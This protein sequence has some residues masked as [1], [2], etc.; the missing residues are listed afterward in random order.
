MV[1]KALNGIPIEYTGAYNTLVTHHRDTP[2]MLACIARTL[3]DRKINIA[4]MR[5][6]REEKGTKAIGIIETDE[7]L[8][9]SALE[10]LALA[11]GIY[12]FNIIEKIY[13]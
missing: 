10:A 13:E 5:L 4:N 11:D 9:P 2:G 7:S 12:Y 8:D 1:I 3:A 6:F